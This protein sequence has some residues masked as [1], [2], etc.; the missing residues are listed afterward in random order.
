[1]ILDLCRALF[2]DIFRNMERTT[3][4]EGQTPILI[5]APHGVDDT[6]TD[7]I[8]ETVAYEFGAYA[9]IN[10]GWKRS[11][12][13]DYWRDLANCN[14]VRHLHSDVVKEE[15]LDPILRSVVKIKRKY[16]ENP[17]VLIIHGCTDKVREISN[18]DYL[19]MIIGYG[20]GAPPSHSCRKRTKDAF[21][22]YLQRENFGV[23]QG[24]VKGNYAGRS[25]NNLNQLFNKWYPD[26]N[27]NC[28]QLEIVR[29]LRC[30]PELISITIDGLVA[31]LDSLMLL[32][33]ATTIPKIECGEV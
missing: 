15:F 9:V 12:S 31:A 25:K 7:Y 32:D 11:E 13:V 19:D 17:F 20:Q 6:N 30:E 3:L 14:D 27:V 2:F 1:M 18:D 22:Y 21:I 28:L 10:K 33:D 26:E 16:M 4:I 23:Y 8:A 29:E 24:K 5:L